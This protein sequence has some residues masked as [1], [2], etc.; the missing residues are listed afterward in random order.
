MKNCSRN[1]YPEEQTSNSEVKA[2]YDRPKYG[3]FKALS[4]PPHQYS[5]QFS[6]S[7]DAVV[8]HK[9]AESMGLPCGT[10]HSIDLNSYTS[11]LW[12][13]NEISSSCSFDFS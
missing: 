8:Y 10:Q 9:V 4:P 1:Q 7:I 3:I 11:S 6:G 13:F 12:A 2:Y 5:I